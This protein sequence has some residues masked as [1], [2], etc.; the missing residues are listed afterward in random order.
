[1]CGLYFTGLALTDATY[2]DEFDR[3]V[4]ADIERILAVRSVYL[5]VPETGDP[6]GA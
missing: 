2:R 1:V 5:A 6:P 4:V 3:R